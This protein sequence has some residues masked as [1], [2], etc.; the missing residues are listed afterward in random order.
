MF[1]REVRKVLFK[2]K[3]KILSLLCLS[4]QGSLQDPQSGQPSHPL[5]WVSP[6]SPNSLKR[7]AVSTPKLGMYLRTESTKEDKPGSV[8]EPRDEERYR[9]GTVSNAR[10]SYL[11]RKPRGKKLLLATAAGVHPVLTQHTAAVLLA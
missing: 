11:K 4:L 9:E 8:S 2:S 7:A 5:R 1:H 3:G 6:T 10:H